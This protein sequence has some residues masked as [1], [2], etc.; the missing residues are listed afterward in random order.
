MH[1]LLETAFEELKEHE[2]KVAGRS[3]ASRAVKPRAAHG[4]ALLGRAEWPPLLWLRLRN[5]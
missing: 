3:E 4:A 1:T 5:G 2:E